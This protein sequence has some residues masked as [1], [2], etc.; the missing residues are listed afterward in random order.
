VTTSS[1][2]DQLDEL[3]VKSK[4]LHE[5]WLK[6]NFTKAGRLRTRLKPELEARSEEIR[7]QSNAISKQI[8]QLT[9]GAYE[10][11]SA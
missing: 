7:K 2:A 1:T 10:A 11:L 8:C 4:E 6:I 5:E 3:F 9:N